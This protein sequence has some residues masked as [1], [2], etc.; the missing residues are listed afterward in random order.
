MSPRRTILH[1]AISMIFRKRQPPA[2]SMPG[3][4]VIAHGSQQPKIRVM[5]F[6]AEQLAG[7]GR[8]RRLGARAAASAT[9]S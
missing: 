6:G 3:T 8:A 5:T 7:A 4:L 9:A 1:Q 2:G